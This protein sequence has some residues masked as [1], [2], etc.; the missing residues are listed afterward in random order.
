MSMMLRLFLLVFSALFLFVIFRLVAKG[1]LQLKY[2]LLWIALGMLLIIA[3]A[4]P[5]LVSWLAQILGVGLTSNFVF[6]VGVIFLMGVCLSLS[7]IVSWQ[8]RDIRS[9]VQRLALLE[10]GVGYNQD[11]QPLVKR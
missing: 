3:S 6:L 7:V 2:S 11:S 10:K 9:L 5:G 8:A 4:F 1:R